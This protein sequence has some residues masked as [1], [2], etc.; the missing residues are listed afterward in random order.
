MHYLRFLIK[1]CIDI[2]ET[3]KILKCVINK[4]QIKIITR[5]YLYYI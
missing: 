5:N 4:A 3:T 2:E 1:N